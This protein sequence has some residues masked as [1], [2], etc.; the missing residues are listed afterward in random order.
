M[1]LNKQFEFIEEKSSKTFD[2]EK[3]SKNMTNSNTKKDKIFS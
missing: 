2:K 1:I 3:P